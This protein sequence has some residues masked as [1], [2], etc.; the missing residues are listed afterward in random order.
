FSFLFVD[1]GALFFNQ[2]FKFAKYD[3]K[4]QSIILGKENAQL[5][6]DVINLAKEGYKKEIVAKLAE[7]RELTETPKWEVPMIISYNSRYK[8][9]EQP[10]S[11]IKPFY[12]AKQSEPERL[13][14]EF[15]NNSKTIKWWYK[16]GESEMKYF[17]V[18]RHDDQAFYPDF[19]IQFKDGKIGIFDTKSGRTAET[20]DAAPRAEALQKYIKRQNK[21]GKKLVGGIAI[22]KNGTWRYN[23]NEEYEYD[24]GDLS[25]WKVLDL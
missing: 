22:Q 13:F 21:K 23:N 1:I 19:I 5:F 8:S 11:V 12:T 17:A 2:K 14:I 25:G 18:L 20:G 4:V 16:N 10:L 24:E 9:E 6:V 15:L 3:P 7:K